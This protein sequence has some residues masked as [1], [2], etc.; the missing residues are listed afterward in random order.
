MV[1][2]W[3]AVTLANLSKKKGR[4]KRQLLVALN[5]IKLIFRSL[6]LGSVTWFVECALR[7]LF[8]RVGLNV[9]FMRIR[10]TNIVRS[11]RGKL[12]NQPRHNIFAHC[13][14]IKVNHYFSGIFV[15]V[16]Q[17]LKLLRL[18]NDSRTNIMANNLL[19]NFLN[20]L[21]FFFACP[22]KKFINSKFQNLFNL[23][24]ELCF[25][26]KLRTWWNRVQPI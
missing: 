9:K 14:I 22:F 26:N 4:R 23:S 25:P 10:T 13:I 15:Q 6:L 8:K 7:S 11:V 20:I 2:K 1:Q 16:V 12:N 19:F 24:P 21:P 3:T 5:I 18:Q 17:T